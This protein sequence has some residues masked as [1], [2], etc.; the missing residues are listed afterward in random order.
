MTELDGNDN[1]NKYVLSVCL[2]KSTD[3]A[4]LTLMGSAFHAAGTATA[5]ER[6]PKL[7]HYRPKYC[8]H[9]LAHLSTSKEGMKSVF[10]DDTELSMTTGRY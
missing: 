5:K 10:C 8:V 7:G 1:Q 4:A 2:N 3:V 6:S 9:N